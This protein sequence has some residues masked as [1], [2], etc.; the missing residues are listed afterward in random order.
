MIVGC[1][2]AQFSG[3]LYARCRMYVA[4]SRTKK[5]LTLV[6]PT[7]NPSPLFKLG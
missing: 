5:S 1:D 2:K 7:V 4:L 6:I 3:T